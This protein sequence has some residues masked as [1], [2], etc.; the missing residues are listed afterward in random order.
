MMGSQT[1]AEVVREIGR[2]LRAYR[3]QGNVSAAEVAA[4]AGVNRNTVV[5]AERGANPRIGTVVRILRALGRLEALDAFLPP[6]ALSPLQLMRSAGRP[7]Q[8]ARGRR[9]G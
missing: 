2:R 5:N 1:D 4:R 9:G 3:L 6:P 8:R 7:R